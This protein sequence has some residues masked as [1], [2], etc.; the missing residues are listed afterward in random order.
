[1]GKVSGNNT[2]GVVLEVNM[3]GDGI[4]DW[5]SKGLCWC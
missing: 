3:V 4:G 2:V 1:M 5:R